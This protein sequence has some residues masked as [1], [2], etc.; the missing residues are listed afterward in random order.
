MRGTGDTGQGRSMG[1]GL[2]PSSVRE[3][4]CTNG[5]MQRLIC[6]TLDPGQLRAQRFGATLAR[7][8]PL[9]LPL[10]LD[11]GGGAEGGWTQQG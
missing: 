1:S 11:G 8:A 7:D 5:P 9:R 4:T 10:P 2:P 6:K 3:T